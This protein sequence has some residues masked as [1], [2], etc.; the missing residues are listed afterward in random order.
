MGTAWRTRL[1]HRTSHGALYISYGIHPKNKSGTYIGYS[2]ALTQKIYHSKY[3]INRFFHLCHTRFNSC[4]VKPS[5]FQPTSHTMKCTKLSI[6]IPRGGIWK[7]NLPRSTSKGASQG[8]IP[9]KTPT[10]ETRRNPNKK[11]IPIKA[12]IH[13]CRTSEVSYRGDILRGTP[14]GV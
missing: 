13:Q 8:G 7:R 4:A 10:G 9:R 3:F 1:V 14:T 5:T 6:E 2:R 12:T 11:F